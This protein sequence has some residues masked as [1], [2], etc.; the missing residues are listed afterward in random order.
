MKRTWFKTVGWLYRP[1]S[2]QGWVLILC[3]LYFMGNVFAVVDGRSHSASDTL[4]GIFPYW[5]STL[6]LLDWIARRTSSKPEA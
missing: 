6:L 1:A 5:A 3:G 4:Y 2:W